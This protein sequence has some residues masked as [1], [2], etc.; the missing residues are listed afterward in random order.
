MQ[1]IAPD[2]IIAELGE[3]QKVGGIQGHTG[4]SLPSAGFPVDAMQPKQRR[5]GGCHHPHK[6][7]TAPCFLVLPTWAGRWFVVS[8]LTGKGADR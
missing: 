6:S 8:G 2:P 5:G 7:T 1:R 4:E 3:H